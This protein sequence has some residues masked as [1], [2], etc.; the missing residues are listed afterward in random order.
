MQSNSL[1]SALNELAGISD[2]LWSRSLGLR[3]K[4]SDPRVTA[5]WLLARLRGHIHAFRLLASAKMTRDSE[6]ALRSAIEA[7]LCLETLKRR[8]SDFM[9][10][11]KS[12]AASTLSGQIPIWASVDPDLAKDADEQRHDVFGS[13]P[14]GKK[15]S[16]FNWHD[17]ADDAA[18]PALYRWYKHLS[19]NSV[20]VTG[21]S[22]VFDG[23]SLFGLSDVIADRRRDAAVWMAVTA[24]IGL[25]AFCE[26]FGHSDETQRIDDILKSVAEGDDLTMGGLG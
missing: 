5:V 12:D 19:A 1:T 18:L 10:M 6:A 26:I 13:P 8:P 3:A 16:R 15:H 17:L 7:A 22:L 25:R 2:A 24:S 20:H 14:G 9:A 11:L 4:V 23:A 21:L